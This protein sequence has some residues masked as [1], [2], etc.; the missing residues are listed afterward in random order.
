MSRFLQEK[1]LESQRHGDMI[2]KPVRSTSN[3]PEII[4]PRTLHDFDCEICQHNFDRCI[5]PFRVKCR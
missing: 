5:R 3:F 4:V 1:P 2:C